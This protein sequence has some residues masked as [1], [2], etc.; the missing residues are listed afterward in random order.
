MRESNW[1][2]A[3]KLAHQF[4]F[5]YPP[6]GGGSR[7]QSED[8]E[9]EKQQQQQQ[10]QMQQRAEQQAQEHAQQRAQQR[11]ER[12]EA[13]ELE[14]ERER[15][16][17]RIRE[18]ELQRECRTASLQSMWV[19]ISLFPFSL[20]VQVFIICFVIWSTRKDNG[21]NVTVS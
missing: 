2:A 16:R 6:H 18:H 20:L 21:F 9:K 17:E 15:E 5:S 10:Q 4:W 12:H 14:R 1:R 19:R 11:A 13:R 7:S 8:K 3:A